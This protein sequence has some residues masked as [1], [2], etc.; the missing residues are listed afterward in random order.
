MNI[1]DCITDGCA[2][3]LLQ[4]AQ[5]YGERMKEESPYSR[6]EMAGRLMTLSGAVCTAAN[7]MYKLEKE[8]KRTLLLPHGFDF[9]RDIAKFIGLKEGL[10]AVFD[11]VPFFRDRNYEAFPQATINDIPQIWNNSLALIGLPLCDD[12]MVGQVF[13]DAVK[14]AYELFDMIFLGLDG[15]I[16]LHQKLHND[17][18]ALQKSPELRA[19]RWQY[20]M[21]DYQEA[22]WENDK[23]SFLRRL[24]NHIR[25]HGCNKGS[26]TA[27][28]NQLDIEATNMISCGIVGELNQRY[29]NQDRHIDFIFENRDT[30]TKEQMTSHMRYVHFRKLLEEEIALCDLRLPAIGAYADLFTCRAAQEIA[31]LLAPTI[32]RFVDFRHNYH[33][34]AWAMAMIDTGLIYADR[35]NGTAMVRF[36]NEAFGEQIDKP[37]LFRYLKRD[38]DFEKIKDQYEVIRSIIN[39]ALGHVSEKDY[40]RQEGQEFFERLTVITKAL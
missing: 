39:Q 4:N 11:K 21:S 9:S 20:M 29:L 27:L 38:D 22:E 1:I 3:D 13:F 24:D 14:F 19:K 40:F 16:K 15:I 8:S 26:L 31:E 10:K 33:Y 36:V 28:L 2:R 32:A 35:R 37:T 30:L 17:H 12:G 25:Q 23:Q 7:S 18:L 5:K 6:L 34:A